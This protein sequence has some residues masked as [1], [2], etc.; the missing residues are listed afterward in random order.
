M[1][2]SV[3]SHISS[4]STFRGYHLS[5]KH[6]RVAPRRPVP[7]SIPTLKAVLPQPLI[8]SCADG[9]S[10]VQKFKSEGNWLTEDQGGLEKIFK[11]EGGEA[12]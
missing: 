11:K 3:C 5:S 1:L 6:T 8:K 12:F 10:V 4:F 9:D 7:D 2:A